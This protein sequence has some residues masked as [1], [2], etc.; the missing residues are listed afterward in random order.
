MKYTFVARN[1]TMA[2]ELPMREFSIVL[3]NAVCA[4]SSAA[5]V[6]AA[7]MTSAVHYLIAFI[8]HA[9]TEMHSVRVLNH[10]NALFNTTFCRSCD[11]RIWRR[12]EEIQSLWARRWEC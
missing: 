8:E 1:L 2:T 3:I 5:C 9:D 6:H 10:F 4:A 12:Y 11:V 7:K